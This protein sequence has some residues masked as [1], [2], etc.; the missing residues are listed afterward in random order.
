VEKLKAAEHGAGADRLGANWIGMSMLC[1][2]H[3]AAWIGAATQ[4]IVRQS[5]EKLIPN[6]SIGGKV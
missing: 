4:L 5:I 6:S 1:G 2:S 3:W